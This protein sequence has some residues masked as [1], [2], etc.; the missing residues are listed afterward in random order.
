[1]AWTEADRVA[2]RSYLG[3]ADLFLQAD[4][5]LESAMNSVQSYADGGARPDGAA[6]ALIRRWLA[7][8]ARI[9]ARLE[10]LWEAAEAGKV[11]DIGV[12]VYRGMAL[13]RS[14]GRRV[15]GR[16]AR[17]LDT[18]PAADAFAAAEIDPDGSRSF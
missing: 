17:A 5:R 15:V 10:E 4:P 9:E 6:E 1:M 16:L 8:L 14:E 18:A 7:Q 12:D 11:D 3:F 2:I 13:L